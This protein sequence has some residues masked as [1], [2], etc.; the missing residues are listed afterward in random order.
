MSRGSLTTNLSPALPKVKKR[1]RGRPF[2]K[3]NTLSLPYRFKKGE[4][5]PNPGGRPKSKEINAA[6][7]EYLKSDTGDSPKVET[8]AQAIVAKIGRKAKKGD[9]GAATFLANRAEGLPVQGLSINN[10]N[11]PLT[12]LV[13]GFAERSKVIGPP[14]GFIP[15][16]KVLEANNDHQ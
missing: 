3:G 4:P 13:R 5:S 8:N 2:E 1:P 16:Q 14:E 12:E 7:R 10:E 15:R 11:D 6:S 9:L